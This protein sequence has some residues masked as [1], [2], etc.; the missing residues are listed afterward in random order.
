MGKNG[1]PFFSLSMKK[2]LI[3]VFIGIIL[4]A[5]FFSCQKREASHFAKATRDKKILFVGDMF[6]DRYIRQVSDAKGGDFIFSCLGDFLKN[7]DLVVGNLEGPITENHS[8]SMRTEPGSP[9]NFTFTF[10]SS[11]AKLLAKNNIKIVNLNNNHIGNFGQD[12]I[13]S[14]K[15][16]LTEAGAAYFNDEQ[17]YRT[18]ISG[19][20]V[21]FVSYN[22]FGGE[23]ADKVVQKILEEKN[24]GQIVFVY[25]HWGDEYAEVPQRIKDIAKLFA[26]S[27]A[28]FI[29]GSHPHIILPSETLRLR[30]GQEI[31]VYYSLGNFIFDQYWNKEVS[32]GLVLE[33]NIKSKEIKIIEHEVFLNNDGRTCLVN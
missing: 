23:S 3:F 7:S 14:T 1:N 25:A 2:I 12:G 29:I 8:K 10:P 22:E 19:I 32:T 17:I 9:E 31:P 16:Y 11:T 24:N 4:F 33:V 20:N 27:R 15:K 18:K 6:F 21:S 13:T 30:S 5:A 26:Q 28:D